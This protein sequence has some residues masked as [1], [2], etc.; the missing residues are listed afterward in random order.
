LKSGP[1][2]SLVQ[3]LLP[4]LLGS[5]FLFGCATVTLP[6]QEYTLARTALEYAESTDSERLAPLLF[7]QAQHFYHEGERMYEERNYDEARSL[8]VKARKLAEKAETTA[9]IK[10]AKSGEVL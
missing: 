9:R 4:C 7:Q 3:S 1:I 8:F 6:Q 5:V 10:K 2:F